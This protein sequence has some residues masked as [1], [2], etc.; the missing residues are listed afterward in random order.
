MTKIARRVKPLLPGIAL[1]LMSFNLFAN[2][3]AIDESK[4]LVYHSAS[5]F[6][7]SPSI[8]IVDVS[9]PE[10]PVQVNNIVVSANPKN[11]F[12]DKE[13]NLLFVAKF[14]SGLDI[15][16]VSDVTAPT[17]VGSWVGTSYD[18]SV[19]NS[20]AYVTTYD[21]Y[22]DVLDTSDVTNI[23][24]INR[25]DYFS[26]S[27]PYDTVSTLA[28]TISGNKLWI[29]G[30]HNVINVFEITAPGELVPTGSRSNN[31]NSF[32]TN[33]IA[34]GNNVAV[35]ANGVF[36]TRDTTTTTV[37]DRISLVSGL[38]TVIGNH[39]Y[40]GSGQ[41]L[42]MFD[43][44]TPASVVDAGIFHYAEEGV[45]GSP[46]GMATQGNILFIVQAGF[47]NGF[48]VFD[49]SDPVSPTLL[50]RISNQYSDGTGE[51]APEPTPEPAPEP[52]PEPI[53]SPSASLHVSD[54]DGI[55]ETR[56]R[57]WRAKVYITVRDHNGFP[58]ENA[59]VDG[60]WSGGASG[61]DDCETDSEGRCQVRSVR[62]N[63]GNSTITFTVTHIS[64]ASLEYDALLNS[65]P[66]G[67]SDGTSI[68]VNQP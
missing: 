13:R 41:D 68:T 23:Q 32:S 50:A 49:V 8:V 21:D 42:R 33:S 45:A 59:V 17:L 57:S 22:I 14:R 1:M 43:I 66:D 46:T 48:S 31:G 2:M 62:V 18:V 61:S 39:A 6:A 16:D 53:P 34:F 26:F 15:F 47:G 25:V 67:D 56:R 9:N 24:S 36:E 29:G 54:L 28:S 4:F 44:T 19:Q 5:L 40:V 12:L 3:M 35:I 64:Y 63:A 30:T 10:N 20:I 27:D 7:P 58:V 55:G 60:N 11:I 52:T 38:V 37:L 51:P 65:D